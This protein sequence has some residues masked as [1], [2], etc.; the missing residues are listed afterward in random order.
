MPALYS[1]TT[2]T[3][4]TILTATI[5]NSDHQNHI[6]N[7]VPAQL[8]DYSVSVSQMQTNTD[9]GEVGTESQA[10]SLAGEIERLRFAIK[11]LKDRVNGAAVAQWYVTATGDLAV[12]DGGTGASTAADARTNLGLGTAAVESYTTGSWTPAITG[13]VSPPTGIS[14]SVQ[15]GKYIR[16][17]AQIFLEFQIIGTITGA[18]S[19]RVELTG[20]PFAAS[21]D[22]TSPVV[23]GALAYLPA[24]SFFHAA[25]G[26]IELFCTRLVA[27]GTSV[28][29]NW[30]D[31]NVSA[32]NFHIHGTLNY[33][34]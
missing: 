11:E 15:I 24:E 30:G 12:A 16:I 8:D 34:V 32:S 5:Y 17:G 14:Y 25:G 27:G 1:H 6:D 19:G 9:P 22:D 23:S 26:S 33:H 29:V 3:T 31:A 18:G 2:R 13:S 4:G 7:G 21:T 20:L 10:T 28:A